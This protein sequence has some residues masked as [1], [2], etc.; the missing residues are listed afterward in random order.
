MMI[1]TYKLH[2][3]IFYVKPMLL[4]FSLLDRK[5]KQLSIFTSLLKS[6]FLKLALIIVL[7]R[8]SAVAEAYNSSII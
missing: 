5:I 8:L 1:E 6:D 4:D 2:I 7:I 3:F